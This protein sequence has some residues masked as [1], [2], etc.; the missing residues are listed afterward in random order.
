MVG[1]FSMEATKKAR[2]LAVFPE[3]YRISTASL[4]ECRY[5]C[6][7]S[8]KPD[9]VISLQLCKSRM[10]LQKLRY[11]RAHNLF[12]GCIPWPFYTLALWFSV[13]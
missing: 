11:L 4:L 5:F 9:S 1:N 10:P 6:K 7:N 8:T 12:R 2:R 3:H 13:P